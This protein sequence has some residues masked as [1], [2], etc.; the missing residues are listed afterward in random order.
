MSLPGNV[1]TPDKGVMC[2]EHSDRVALKTVQGETDSFGAEY[3]PMCESC[4][5]AYSDAVKQ[6]DGASFTGTCDQCKAVLPLYPY[7]DY[8]EGMSGPVYYACKS[9][10]SAF[11][12]A[13]NKEAEEYLKDHGR[14][15]EDWGQDDDDEFDREEELALNGDVHWVVRYYRSRRLVRSR[16][17]FDVFFS[18]QRAAQNFVR[19]HRGKL[20]GKRIIA[21]WIPY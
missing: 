4:Y 16:R 18:S 13:Q 20:R 21:G 7:R 15:F 14:Y 12:A 5:A 3:I 9:C 17:H 6:A 19:R 11:R 1:T 8:D 10:K 2:L